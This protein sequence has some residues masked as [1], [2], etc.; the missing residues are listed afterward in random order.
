M[1]QRRS[2]T[3][4]SP[5][6]SLNEDQWKRYFE[7]LE[8]L[9]KLPVDQH[10]HAML[11]W[12][13]A[14]EAADILSLVKLR[15]ALA[16]DS[17]RCRTGECIRHFVLGEQIGR[18][19]MG[20][21]YRAV[22]DF[23]GGIER[24][25]AVKLI[26]P[27]LIAH[28]PDEARQRFQQEI[29]MLVKLD[30]KGIARIYDGGLHR[31][32][33]GQEETLFF[34]MELVQGKPLNDY[35][36]EYRTTL[37]VAGI[38][39]L[40]RQVCDA[41]S[42]A[43]QQGVVHRDLKPSNILIDA[44]AEARI[45]DFGLAQN[46][47]NTSVQTP[48][49][50][51]SGTPAYMS[52]E[53]STL[54]LG[55][56]TTVSDIYAL[57][58]ILYELLAGHRPRMNKNP[59]QVAHAEI[60]NTLFASLSHLCPGYTGE[61]VQAVTKAMAPRP[62]DR[63]AS[64]AELRHAVVHCLDAAQRQQERSLGCR[65]L[66]MKKVEEFWINGVLKNSLLTLVLMD[67]DLE[68]HPEAT[69]YPWDLIV[70]I[71]HQA[72]TILAPGTKIS[73]VFSDLT[74]TMLI[75]G[76]PGAGK[77]TLLLELAQELLNQAKQDDRL[78][79][80][81]VFHLSTWVEQR[82][83][84]VEWLTSELKKRYDL[85]PR[86]ARYCLENNQ[87]ILLLDGLDEVALIWRNGCVAA[88]NAFH[89]KYLSTSLAVCSRSADYAAL[90]VRLQL[91]GAVMIQTLTRR[92]IAEYLKRAGKSLDHVR[93]ALRHDEQLWDL[94]QTPL[95]L[96]I[97]VLVYQRCPDTVMQAAKTLDERR[98]QL[99]AAYTEA[100]FKR[101]G[102]A[103]RY[104][105]DQ[106]VHWLTWLA[107]TMLRQH[108][109]VFYLEWMQPDW[110][111]GPIQRWLVSVGSVILCGL[112]VGI[113]VGLSN[114][115]SNDLACSLSL[116]LAFGLGGG[117]GVG[118]LGYGDK[119]KPVTK[120][121]W[122]WRALRDKIIQNLSFAAVI[123][124][125]LGG[126]IAL[127]LE[128]KIGVAIGLVTAV[129]FSYFYGID[130]DLKKKDF[131]HLTMPNRAIHRSL[132]N[133]L[134]GGIAGAIT[135][136]VAGGLADGWSGVWFGAAVFGLVIALLYGGHPCLQHLILRCLLWHNGTAPWHYVRFLD[137]AV[138]RI[139]LHRV[140]GSYAFIHRALLEYFAGQKLQKNKK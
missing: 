57:G 81:V 114:G 36:T 136:A 73:N 135:G 104:T 3:L 70:Q 88:I 43:H 59:T 18:G 58:V 110:L 122:S 30:H 131:D 19:G 94:L 95:M 124:L 12:C 31:D 127:I 87:L 2:A 117:L 52:P 62:K 5:M 103:T 106:T 85:P 123:G 101:R 96:S 32:G 46:Y 125:L 44:N 39:C 132:R 91:A 75:L 28:T 54:G 84:L 109:S 74:E 86:A 51:L 128:T 11:E 82:L 4:R 90:A 98:T 108:Q 97:T 24:Q 40:F 48:I 35:V 72:P 8:Q 38:L 115:L 16:P 77:T 42:Y 6:R 29:G 45:I 120:L 102:K 49:E 33:H 9:E 79:I 130:L 14:G 55:P 61:L 129:A 140:G 41:L 92:K 118:L 107:S 119:I 50:H 15:L 13:A 21:V 47:D 112:L 27:E 89:R 60:S 139:L 137:S 121:R 113:V 83:P 111:L 100:V 17:D 34:A 37:G 66:L 126:G 116:S 25:V 7:L 26:H 80:P 76:A 53:Q 68:L 67:L 71:P 56:V 20:I 63:F 10:R 1:H 105:R 78:R 138:E 23:S 64:V 134:T 65:Y 133:A 22:Q 69:E 93:V 99:F